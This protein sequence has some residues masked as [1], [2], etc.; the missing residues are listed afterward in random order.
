[1]NESCDLNL[2]GFGSD[3]YNCVENIK[4]NMKRGAGGGQFL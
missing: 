3:Q 1:M 4:N 2:F